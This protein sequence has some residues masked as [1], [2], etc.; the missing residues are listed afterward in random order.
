MFALCQSFNVII[1]NYTRKYFRYFSLRLCLLFL[2]NCFPRYE[3]NWSWPVNTGK[4]TIHDKFGFCL[5]LKREVKLF[6]D[7]VYESVFTVARKLLA[8]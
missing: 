5:R 2:W 6:Y 1:S 3:T 7:V 4:Y 8:L